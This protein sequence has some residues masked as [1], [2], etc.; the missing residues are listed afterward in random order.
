V[1]AFLGRVDRLFRLGDR[2]ISRPDASYDIPCALTHVAKYGG[3]VG[4]AAYLSGSSGENFDELRRRIAEV[5]PHLNLE[6]G[7]GG[8]GPDAEAWLRRQL[9]GL[10]G[11][12][13]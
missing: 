6:V 7:A 8:T 1:R 2:P 5:A 4:A 12:T 13:Q 10:G 3:T 9:E 11:G